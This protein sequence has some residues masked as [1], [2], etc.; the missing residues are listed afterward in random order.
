MGTRGLAPIHERNGKRVDR[1]ESVY[2]W[3]EV[4]GCLKK[5]LLHDLAEQFKTDSISHRRTDRYMYTSALP[6]RLE[7]S[8]IYLFNVCT[9]S[10]IYKA[11]QILVLTKLS[12]L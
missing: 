10:H 1:R 8:F 7:Y 2:T 5:V 9:H 4:R 11:L 12:S 3:V 6:R